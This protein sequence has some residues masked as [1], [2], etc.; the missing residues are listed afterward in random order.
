MGCLSLCVS[1]ISQNDADLCAL[2]QEAFCQPVLPPLLPD[3]WFCCTEQTCSCVFENGVETFYITPAGTFCAETQEAA[4]AQAKAYACEHCG[5]LETI[6]RLGPLDACTCLG[7]NYN[8]RIGYEGATPVSWLV[9]VGALPDGLALN[10][11]TGQIAGTPSVA[12]IFVFTIRANLASGNWGTRTYA[13]YV[14]EITTTALTDFTLGDAYSFQMQAAG[15]SGNYLWRVAQG[16]LPTGL[17]MSS[18]GLISG[19]PTA[20]GSAAIQF[21]VI[22]T[23]CENSNQSYFTPLVST[24]S[25]S[26]TTVRTRRGYE[27]YINS[28]G[29]LYK[30][31]SFTGYARQRAYA[32]NTYSPLSYA[33]GAEYLYSGSSEINN[34]GQFISSH[35]KDLYVNC[36]AAPK[37][38]LWDIFANLS[39]VNWLLGYCWPADPTTCPTC[40]TDE[41]DWFFKQN[42]ATHS[43]DD[44]A[45]DIIAADAVSSISPT[46]YSVVVPAGGTSVPMY[47]GSQP[48]FPNNYPNPINF[49]LSSLN[50][51]VWYYVQLRSEIDYTATLSNLFTDQDAI[52]GQVQYYSNGRTSENRPNYVSWTQD[53]I[54]NVSSRTTTA[55][56]TI[57][58]SN[59]V[60]GESYTVRYEFWRNDGQVTLQTVVF[61]AS[62][63][64]HTINGSLPT[65]TAGR[66]I[67]LKNVRIAYT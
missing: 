65:P 23:T 2:A 14:I 64:T 44:K 50:G 7:T 43:H 55:N 6:V 1:E 41:A 49:P 34:L 53:F 54:Y 10:S 47:L 58:C 11:A 21:E 63:T 13:I 51:I 25:T 5:D 60:D 40:S 38:H 30:K 37:L 4:D 17:T 31:V 9:I 26:Q 56:F 59:L 29:A 27:E 19:T 36:L 61:T 28:T 18:T 20:V 66:T 33:G 45:R 67:T 39:W 42:D 52:N 15:G 48:D 3:E 35:R 12:G 8:E 24:T 62:G 32:V 46:S 57:N 16:T 22:D